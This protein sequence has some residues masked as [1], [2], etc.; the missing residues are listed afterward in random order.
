MTSKVIYLLV[1]LASFQCVL[2]AEPQK[3]ELTDALWNKA[4]EVRQQLED[5]MPKALEATNNATQQISQIIKSTTQNVQQLIQNAKEKI[6]SAVKEAV[7]AGKMSQNA[8]LESLM[9]SRKSDHK[10]D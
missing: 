7:Q 3:R 1:V 4:E 10:Q 2:S 5:A 9:L 6:N 8:L